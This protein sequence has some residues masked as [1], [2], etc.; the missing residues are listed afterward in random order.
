MSA[1]GP[2]DRRQEVHVSQQP[3]VERREVVLEDV[4]ARR[5]LTV[6]RVSALVGLLFSVLEAAIG[7]R[8]LLKLME[9]NPKNAFASFVYNFTALFLAP[10]AGLTPN[11]AVDGM[12]LEITS[13]MAMI[14]YA[15]IALAIIRLVWLVFYQP[16]ARSVSMYERDQTPRV[17]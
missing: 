12:I 4:N 5:R 7:L 16:S 17:N 1:I 2:V 13:I 8:V 14:V 15:L 9:A 3:G 10:F 6:D 11:P